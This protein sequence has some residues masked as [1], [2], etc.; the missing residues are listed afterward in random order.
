MRPLILSALAILSL[1]GIF[2]QQEIIEQCTQQQSAIITGITGKCALLKGDKLVRDKMTAKNSIGLKLGVGEKLQCSPGGSVRLFFCNSKKEI[3]VKGNPTKWFTVPAV[4]AKIP[5]EGETEIKGRPRPPERL[6]YFNIPNYQ[7]I[8]DVNA[9]LDQ[10]LGAA[11]AGVGDRAGA[12]GGATGGGMGG[13][14]GGGVGGRIG[15][16]SSGANAA[17]SKASWRIG[18]PCHSG[19]I[20][21]SHLM[22]RWRASLDSSL[23]VSLM[24]PERSVLWTLKMDSRGSDQIVA[25]A[26]SSELQKFRDAYPSTPVIFSATRE[27]G[28]NKEC[29]LSLLTREDEQAL[30]QELA[31]ITEEHGLL[32]HLYRAD[33]FHRRQLYSE[34]A[35]EYDSILLLSPESEDLLVAAMIANCRARNLERVAQLAQQ[36][37]GAHL[38]SRYFCNPN[39]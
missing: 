31:D 27:N 20:R 14:R 8:I 18:S 17:N 7:R 15:D 23:K 29:A 19:K 6:S 25:D 3:E 9:G 16:A 30:D 35:E 11:A 37:P 2:S 32:L 13:A 5:Q 12:R 10:N 26:N 24:S 38:Y 4:P 36:L 21:A 33:A 39:E 34:E 1:W 28:S 22:V